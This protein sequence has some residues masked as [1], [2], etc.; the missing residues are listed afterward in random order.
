[1]KL[2]RVL[3]T[4]T[5][6]VPEDFGAAASGARSPLVDALDAL[7]RAESLDGVATKVRRVVRALPLGPL[8]DVL[9]GRQAGH[10][11]HPALVQVPVGAWLSAAVLDVLP[12]GR[13]GARVLVGVGTVAA[14]PAALAGWVDWAE[15]HEQQMRTGLVH[16]G[17]NVAAVTL[18]AG[19]WAARGRRPGLGRLLGFAGLVAAGTGG[20]VGGH[21]AYRQ[22]AG[23]NK[24]EPV[25]HLVEPGWHTIGRTGDFPLGEPVRHLLGEVPLLVV[26]AEGDA[27]SVLADRCS[28][29]SGPLSE[30]EVADGCVTC[31]WHGSVFRLSDGWN[32]A[33]PAT[34]PQPCFET[35]VDADGTVS[36]RLPD[37]G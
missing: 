28:H 2:T 36:V 19:S 35:R 10:P 3:L 16:A 25:P 18:Y 23:A 13:R 31:P 21:L 8:R 12:G 17:C 5:T 27:V 1:M 9:H 33:G 11:L 30:G 20:L 37:A 14:V 6:T 26:R 24:A 22:G 4:K 32:V 29:A 7:G 34:A 15:Q